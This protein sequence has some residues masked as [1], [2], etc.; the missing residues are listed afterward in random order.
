MMCHGED[1]MKVKKEDSNR[2]WVVTAKIGDS[3]QY[4]IYDFSY[5]KIRYRINCF[6]QKERDTSVG[7]SLFKTKKAAEEA[8]IRENELR[9][10]ERNRFR[11]DLRVL[12]EAGM[13]RRYPHLNSAMIRCV[14]LRA[15]AKIKFKI[16]CIKDYDRFLNGFK[17]LKGK[18]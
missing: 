4:L 14:N 11:E 10:H 12:R 13:L 8:I 9:K 6:G 16:E 15:F 18:H 3:K 2:R 1:V 17:M 7:I 5:R